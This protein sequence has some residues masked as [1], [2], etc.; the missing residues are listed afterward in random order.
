[1]KQN[2]LWQRWFEFRQKNK[3]GEAYDETTVQPVFKPNSSP[4][5]REFVV[6]GIGRFGKSVAQTLHQSGHDVLAIDWDPEQVQRLSAQLPNVVQLDAT[7]AEALRQIGIESFET[8]VICMSSNFE[9]S[10]L[11][12]TLLLKFGVKRVICK[13]R[14]RTQKSILETLGAHQVILP[15]HEAG[16]HLGRKLATRHFIDYLEVSDDVSIIEIEAPPRLYGKTLA[17][18]DLR[19]RVGL[20]VIAV[21]RENTVL[22]NPM[23]DFC[24]E[25]GDELMVIGRIEDVERLSTAN[26]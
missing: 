25:A 6:I 18:C 17:E 4:R 24:I 7:N 22:A 5:R 26:L 13:A 3:N 2:R 19:K 9:S 8:G 11:A 1:M 20:T 10:L 23:A 12:T 16:V 14:T 15:E 21:N